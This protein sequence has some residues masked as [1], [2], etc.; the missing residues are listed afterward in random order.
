MFL[1]SFYAF[2]YSFK[3]FQYLCLAFIAYYYPIKDFF[4]HFKVYRL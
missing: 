2:V 1:S 3:Y 4:E